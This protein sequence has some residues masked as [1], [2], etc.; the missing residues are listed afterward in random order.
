MT[1]SGRR[2]ARRRGNH[3]PLVVH[4][5]TRFLQGGSEQRLCDLLTALPDWHHHVIIGRDSDEVLAR[6]RLSGATVE[7]APHLVRELRPLSDLRASWYLLRALRGLRP[8]LV[9]TH[10][11]KAGVIG[12]IGARAISAP[13]VQS[14]SMAGFGPGYSKA[15]DLLFRTVERA[16]APIT[17]AYAVVGVDLGRRYRRAGIDVAQVVIRSGARLPQP[18]PDPDRVAAR[19]RFLGERAD[20]ADVV[21]C[22]GSLDERKGVLQLPELMS[23]LCV[24]PGVDP[25]LLVAGEGPL[26]EQLGHQLEIQGHRHRSELLGHVTDLDELFGAADLVILLSNAEGLPQV[27]VQAASAGVPFVAYDVDGVREL[28]DRGAQGSVVP[29]GAI[30]RVGDE[31]ARWL[32]DGTASDAEFDL[33]EWQP[34]VILSQYRAL[35][36]LVMGD[37]PVVGLL[38]APA[39]SQAATG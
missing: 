30:D 38:R 15:K 32:S 35:V 13:T 22:I 39:P 29:L 26:E 18:L 34:E 12:R 19:K 25:H 33:H 31:A 2:I 7:V 8:A 24:E 11:S 27:L 17:S 23:R 37:S 9:I 21:L 10:Q 5:C 14:L 1:T 36:S 20:D 16:L 3:R 6:R 28:L 4:V